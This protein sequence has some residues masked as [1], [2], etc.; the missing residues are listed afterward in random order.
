MLRY[1]LDHLTKNLRSL[2]IKVVQKSINTHLNDFL[3]DLV[4]YIELNK[5]V[6]VPKLLE[7]AA[8]LDFLGVENEQ[9]LLVEVFFRAA[10]AVHALS[11]GLA[12]LLFL[13]LKFKERLLA[14]HQEK[15]FEVHFLVLLIRKSL[16]QKLAKLHVILKVSTLCG[17][18]HEYD[19][20]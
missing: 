5:Q 12:L 10:A 2:I 8:M 14:L 18:F 6:H 16:E 9:H 20:H 3:G 1:L 13:G 15:V 17:G 7:L 4:L 19:L 11:S